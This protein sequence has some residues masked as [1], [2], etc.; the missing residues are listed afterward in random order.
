MKKGSKPA[1]K[2][3][4][5]VLL[6]LT[7]KHTLYCGSTHTTFQFNL[8]IRFHSCLYISS[9][10]AMSTPEAKTVWLVH[11]SKIVL[12]AYRNTDNFLCMIYGD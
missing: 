6:I 10:C 2:Q 3:A 12:Y 11:V 1:W 8:H 5:V 9:A 7:H 4:S